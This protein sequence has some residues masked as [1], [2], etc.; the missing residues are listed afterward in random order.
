VLS[1]VTVCISQLLFR[2]E[3]V[4]VSDLRRSTI[5]KTSFLVFLSPG[6]KFLNQ[7]TVSPFQIFINLSSVI[8]PFSVMSWTITA[9]T[10]SNTKIASS[11]L[12]RINDI[13]RV[14]Y[15]VNWLGRG[16]LVCRSSIQRVST[17]SLNLKSCIASKVSSKLSCREIPTTLWVND[18]IDLSSN[19]LVTFPSGSDF[20]WPTQGGVNFTTVYSL[21]VV[22]KKFF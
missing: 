12:F 3:E 8:I 5:P 18:E 17:G 11:N 9:A 20:V 2:I 16:L 4:R 21:K 10:W 14:F 13:C 1:N 6:E 22:R 7:T 15:G 19:N